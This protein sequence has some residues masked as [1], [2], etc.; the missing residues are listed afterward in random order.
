VTCHIYKSCHVFNK[1][2]GT[3]EDSRARVEKTKA[4]CKG[5]RTRS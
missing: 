4:W 2:D 5:L 1:G 3:E